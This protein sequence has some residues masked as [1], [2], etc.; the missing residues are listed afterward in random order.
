MPYIPPKSS[1]SYPPNPPAPIAPPSSSSTAAPAVAAAVIAQKSHPQAEPIRDDLSD[2][3]MLTPRPADTLPEVS[4]TTI[5]D[6]S[7]Q[8][9]S[10]QL[11]MQSHNAIDPAMSDTEL[12]PSSSNASLV[13]MSTTR[14]SPEPKSAPSESEVGTPPTS[15]G[16]PEVMVVEDRVTRYR[17]ELYAYTVS[18]VSCRSTLV[19]RWCEESGGSIV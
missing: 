1:S 18:W 3:A 10:T 4:T 17:E 5:D 9:E 19:R 8:L 2:I 15:H 16:T 7:S 6:L 14:S 13:S 11:D 12:N